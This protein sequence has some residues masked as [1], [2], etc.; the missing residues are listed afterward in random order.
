MILLKALLILE[1]WHLKKGNVLTSCLEKLSK[2]KELRDKWNGITSTSPNATSVF[3]LQNI[4]TFF[5]QIK[6]ANS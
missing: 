1:I 3:V 2:N 4:V 5:C 6:A